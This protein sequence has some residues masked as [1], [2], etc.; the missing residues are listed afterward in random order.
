MVLATD[1][2]FLVLSPVN[3]DVFIYVFVTCVDCE[4]TYVGNTE[5]SNVSY[6]SAKVTC[7]INF[8]EKDTWMLRVK[9]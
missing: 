6:V 3:N 8:S 4:I 1:A 7:R 9:I 2:I 5:F